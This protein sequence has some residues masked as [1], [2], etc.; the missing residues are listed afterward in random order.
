[1]TIFTD[2]RFKVFN[3]DD[4]P[5]NRDI[6]MMDEVWAKDREAA[7]IDVFEGRGSE[8]YDVGY[9]LYCSAVGVGEAEIELE[10][11]ADTSTRFHAVRILLP[12]SAFVVCMLAHEYEKRPTLFVKSDW[13]SDIY[14][15]R[16][17]IWHQWLLRLAE[18]WPRLVG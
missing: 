4:I 3:F 9:V 1:L 5:L 7:W 16:Q 12:K 15:R 13:L 14:V 10:W 18:R 8:P 11:F 6:F 17:N 2:E